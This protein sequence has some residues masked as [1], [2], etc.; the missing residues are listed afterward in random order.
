MLKPWLLVFVVP[1]LMFGCGGVALE[2]QNASC[3]SGGKSYQ[4]CA[5]T[6]GVTYKYGGKSCSA[7]STNTTQVENCAQNIAEYCEGITDGGTSTDI[8]A[9]ACSISLTGAITA[10]YACMAV[11]TY[12]SGSNLGGPVLAVTMPNGQ[13][14]ASVTITRPGM[15]TSGTYTNT[16]SG[17]EG[18][19]TGN[20]GMAVWLAD[21]GSPSSPAQGTYSMD[22][23]VESSST[24]SSGA[25]YI[26]NGTVTGTLPAVTGTGATGTVN[27]T[28]SF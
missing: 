24:V 22:L 27:L 28:A 8:A 4:T 19:L 2:C 20:Q 5:T 26:A 15:V 9:H 7:S 12:A 14:T 10:T 17:A 6:T 25:I 3:Q 18:A 21:V 23:T 11:T 13:N 1:V 16:D